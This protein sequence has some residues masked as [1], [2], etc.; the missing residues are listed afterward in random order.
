MSDR[1]RPLVF[2]HRWRSG[3]RAPIERGKFPGVDTGKLRLSSTLRTVHMK[4]EK[5]FA[6][7]I[8]STRFQNA[9]F[10]CA[11]KYSDS[12]AAEFERI[13]GKPVSKYCGECGRL[14]SWCECPTEER[15]PECKR[16]WA[17]C[18]CGCRGERE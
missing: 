17:D 9:W 2:S 11:R 10:Q 7:T 1:I 8:P 12:A 14:W 13:F 3:I 6:D 15:C 4:K 16:D 18:D 5:G